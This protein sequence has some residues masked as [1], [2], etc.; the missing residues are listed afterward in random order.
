[1]DAR[2]LVE[3]ELEGDWQVIGIKARKNFSN[4]QRFGVISLSEE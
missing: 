2:K 4:K 3:K 1:L